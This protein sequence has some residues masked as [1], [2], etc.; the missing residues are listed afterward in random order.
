MSFFHLVAITD[1]P[2][3]EDKTA[4]ETVEAL[5]QIRADPSE[6]NRYPAGYWVNCLAYWQAIQP[7]PDYLNFEERLE[8]NR[9]RDRDY[10]IR[11]AICLKFGVGMVCDVPVK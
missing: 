1:D 5:Y 8:K 7:I 11:H 3:P 6:R 4:R 2:T 9:K 10:K